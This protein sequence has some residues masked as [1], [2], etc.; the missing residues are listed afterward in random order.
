M[1]SNYMTSGMA[2]INGAQLYYEVKGMG[3]PLLLVHAGVADSRMWE[4]QFEAFS[5]KYKVIRFDREP[6]V[7]V[8]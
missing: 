2:N 3:Q 5:K 7:V 1:E 4:A 8:P 6:D